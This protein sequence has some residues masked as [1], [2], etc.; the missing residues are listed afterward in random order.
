MSFL[1]PLA[2][3]ALAAAAIPL[4]VHLFNFRR[5]RRVDFSSLVFLREVERSTMQRVRLQQWLLLLLRTLAIAMLV[6]AFARPTL[7]AQMA[8]IIG[9][10]GSAALAVII[11]DSPSMAA[12]ERTGERFRTARDAALR[13]VHEADAK[14]E[15]FLLTTSR[16]ALSTRNLSRSAAEEIIAGLELQ[17]FGRPHVFA[18]SEAAELL[19]SSRSGRGDAFLVTDLQRALLPDSLTSTPV[20]GLD[21]TI[22][23]VG[24][25]AGSNLAVTEVSVPSRVID[26]GHPVRVVATISNFSVTDRDA[27]PVSV[28][29]D[30]ERVARSEV[31]VEAGASAD[32]SFT[33]TPR[34]HGW[35]EG[36]I[37]LDD[38]DALELDNER[39]FSILVPERR[40]VL[41]VR[42]PTADLRYI[43]YALSPEV[44]DG[45]VVF[46]PT[47]VPASALSS[48][49]PASYDA[50]VLAGVP[51]FTSG[52]IAAIVDYVRAGGGVLVYPGRDASVESYN[53]LFE[54][55]GAGAIEGMTGSPDSG[56]PIASISEIDGE[57][58]LF[59]GVFEADSDQR[60]EPT[61]V[62]AVLRMAGT[63]ERVQTLVRLSNGWPFLNE[64]RE[65]SGLVFLIASALE[66][67]WTDLAVRGLFVPLLYRMMFHLTASN[68]EVGE[69]LTLSSRR[70]INIPDRGVSGSVTAVAPDGAE[71]ALEQRRVLGAHRLVVDGREL[72]TPGIARLVDERGNVLRMVAV[73]TDPAESD[74]ALRAPEEAAS[75]LSEQLA[76]G[77]DVLPGHGDLSDFS[78]RIR[79]ARQGVEVWNVFL[80]LALG[81]L[82]AEMLVARRWRPDSVAA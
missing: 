21:V 37:T 18:L 23:A 60:V 16:G 67:A 79:A 55:L 30:G 78:R 29:I 52:E 3:I 40:R 49:A 2:L 61:D 57:H 12:I 11:D 25:R 33:V 43:E 71:V 70:T 1:N 72:G 7:T 10:R 24:E 63:S 28:Y 38:T 66:P 31:A 39:H 36:L 13:I 80:L 34:S 35:K 77:V 47:I 81:F 76:T 62:Y 59:E 42:G 5:P 56:E 27:L 19:Q 32:V 51:S 6:V 53:A 69:G 4:I 74:P 8:G 22:V 75:I 14:D 68:A 58:S 45:R 64:L 46:E 17:A 44:S 26:T 20:G 73:N 48:Q 65:G 41:M 82:A 50:V 15:I 9:D 54:R